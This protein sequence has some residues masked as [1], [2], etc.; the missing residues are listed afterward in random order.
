MKK[1][2]F[3]KNKNIFYKELNK[4][5]TRIGGINLQFLI[6]NIEEF[7]KYFNFKDVIY[8]KNKKI[9]IKFL[10]DLAHS[11]QDLSEVLKIEPN[12]IGLNA[13]LTL[14]LSLDISKSMYD[15]KNHTLYFCE[16]SACGQIAIFYFTALLHYIGLSLLNDELMALD[17]LYH[18]NNINK[19]EDKKLK[20]NFLNLLNNLTK[21]KIIQAQ[22]KIFI[23]PKI[24]QKE[25]NIAEQ[26]IKNFISNINQK[27]IKYVNEYRNSQNIKYLENINDCDIYLHHINQL[28]N[29]KDNNNLYLLINKFK[30]ENKLIIPQDLERFLF[31]NI[32]PIQNEPF[33]IYKVKEIFENNN[34]L[35]NNLFID[36]LDKQIV[37]DKSIEWATPLEL[38]KKAFICFVYDKLNSFGRVN[39]YL[40]SNCHNEIFLKRFDSQFKPFI[41]G[42]ER[43]NINIDF[44][45]F[46]S[47][48]IFNNNLKLNQQHINFNSRQENLL[49]LL[50]SHSFILDII[51]KNDF[52]STL[53]INLKS[54][55]PYFEKAYALGIENT[56]K[57]LLNRIY[58]SILY[59]CPHYFSFAFNRLQKNNQDLTFFF[60]HKKNII[61]N[62]TLNENLFSLLPKSLQYDKNL[63]IQVV[64]KNVNLLNLID[65]SLLT[66]K[67]NNDFIQ[68]LVKQNGLSINYIGTQERRNKDIILQAI[69]QNPNSYF[70]LD[71]ICKKNLNIN[72]MAIN[73]CPDL[74]YS[75]DAN[76]LEKIKPLLNQNILSKIQQKKLF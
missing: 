46:I 50:N 18:L 15:E 7:K 42:I 23:A 59:Q 49:N 36:N 3:L 22:D 60:K 33:Y 52:K 25:K 43:E 74:I 13:T 37:P 72:H 63:I 8:D 71:N 75:I 61:Q 27:K 53:Q 16:K 41:E 70:Y 31:I 19:I 32:A 67:E 6:T 73:A 26:F 30:N 5:N 17:F 57:I 51:N 47:N 44:N 12:L 10:L 56:E 64:K 66:G 34:Y 35:K 68:K 58:E 55:I 39:E 21:N 28:L 69:K 29:V 11:F 4:Y 54:L 65:P 9:N 1:I 38:F 20:N 14:D 24:S 76:I 45:K 62:L 40:T 2:Q 48:L